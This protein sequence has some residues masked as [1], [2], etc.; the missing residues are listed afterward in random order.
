MKKTILI[1]LLSFLFVNYTHAQTHV[2]DSL[3]NLIKNEKR[4]TVRVMLLNELSFQ[5]VRSTPDSAMRVALEGL[6]LSQK[7]S[8]DRGTAASLNKIGDAYYAVGNGPKAME[9]WVQ[10]M[11]INEKINNL[12]GKEKNLANMALVYES[13]GQHRLDIEYSM[14]SKK[15]NEQINNQDGLAGNFI[16]ISRA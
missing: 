13:Q 8:F 5:Y 15:I 14:R 10:A 4:D 12:D 1:L 2:R 16:N 11:K 9:V 7:I 3:K 6:A